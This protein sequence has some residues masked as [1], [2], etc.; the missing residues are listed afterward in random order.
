MVAVVVTRDGNYPLGGM[1]AVAECTGHAVVVDVDGLRPAAL[2]AVLA[3]RVK[4]AAVVVLP[5]SPDG[6]DLAPRLA[7]LLG[8]PLLA[9]AVSVEPGRAT[10]A[11]RGGLVLE[12]HAVEG[13]YVAT[14]LCG[15]RGVP[16]GLES[17][18]PETLGRPE[19]P[20]AGSAGS[21][22]VPDPEVVE[23]VTSAASDLD[24]DEAKLILAVG[25]G[26]RDRGFVELAGQV[27]DSLGMSL[28]ATRVVTDA[29]WLPF[30]R[31]IGT[32][33]V[34]VDPDIYVALAI[35]GAV[36]HVSGLGEPDH[37]VSINTDRSCPMSAMADTN[38]VCDA[39]GVL[40][41]MADRLGID[42]TPKLRDE[43]S[44]D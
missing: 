44:S 10:L 20:S 35:S 21:A 11:R 37:V 6:R 28:G 2:A 3:G 17:P 25:A 23:V 18:E 34:M 7:A 15:V 29:G 19:S 39:R 5:A 31:Q 1:E 40:V 41:A 32:T 36:Q 14:L 13:P 26:L 9:G 4:E 16:A 43:V 38:I 12:T 42:V 24:L 33:G 27:A 22:G 8:R 30:E